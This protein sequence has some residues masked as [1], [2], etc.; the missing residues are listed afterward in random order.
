[1]TRKQF[2]IRFVGA[3]LTASFIL[4]VAWA[5]NQSV[6]TASGTVVFAY[7]ATREVAIKSTVEKIVDA[8]S[9]ENISGTHLFVTTAQ[10]TVDAHL[11]PSSLWKSQNVTL[12]PGAAV[13]LTGVFVNFDGKSV[14]LA[15]TL[16]SGNSIILLRNEHG[17]LAHAAG[18]RGPLAP[19]AGQGAR[20]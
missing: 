7:D 18:P 20:P 8:Q 3:A 9:P 16:K 2:F 12:A 15:R 13:E 4:S 19:T 14:L 5:Q 11:G 10:G 17:F 6:P 1:M